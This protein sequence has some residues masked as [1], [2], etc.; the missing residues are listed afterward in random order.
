M[1]PALHHEILTNSPS[2]SALKGERYET[3][4]KETLVPL[5]ASFRVAATKFAVH[6]SQMHHS[7]AGPFISACHVE[8]W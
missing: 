6:F 7:Y 8:S 3:G 1:W 2:W 4:E 5:V